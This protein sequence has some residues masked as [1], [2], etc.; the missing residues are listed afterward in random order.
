MTKAHKKLLTV[1]VLFGV[2]T[3][4]LLFCSPLLMY[5]S[6]YI[7][8]HRK[9]EYY[10]KFGQ[11]CDLIMSQHPLGTNESIGLSVTDPS[12]PKIIRDVNPIKI[13]VGRTGVSLLRGGSIQFGIEWAQDLD[14]TNIWVLSTTCESQNRILYTLPK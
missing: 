12:L 6:L 9:I 7:F 4:A 1:F 2:I 14:Q 11:A 3:G 10:K 8:H 5:P 13:G